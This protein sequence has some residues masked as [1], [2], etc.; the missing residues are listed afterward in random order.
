MLEHKHF[1]AVGRSYRL[2]RDINTIENWVLRLID[3]LDMNVLYGPFTMYCDLDGNKGLTS[4]TLLTTSHIIIHVFEDQE[5]SEVQLDV[6]SCSKVDL[7]V[8]MSFLSELDIIEVSYKFL[9]RT[10]ELTE[11][12]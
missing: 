2:F 3:A 12:K 11:I 5:D 7:D 6:Y 4:V 9:D 1:I 8:I 10:S